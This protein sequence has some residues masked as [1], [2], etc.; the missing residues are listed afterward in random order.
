MA[1]C[2][3]WPKMTQRSYVKSKEFGCADEL[4]EHFKQNGNTKDRKLKCLGYMGKEVLE[5]VNPSSFVQ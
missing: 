1:T 5:E 4:R 2:R 3:P